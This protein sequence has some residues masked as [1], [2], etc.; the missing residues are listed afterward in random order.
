M[1]YL[2]I[3]SV[4]SLSDPTLKK[5]KKQI[6]NEEAFIVRMDKS[7]LNGKI[8]EYSLVR[9]VDEKTFNSNI[10]SMNQD[11]RN[12]AIKLDKALREVREN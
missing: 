4:D 9:S 1:K 5:I 12:R 6:K 3:M 8:V 10:K 2:E 11:E 7:I